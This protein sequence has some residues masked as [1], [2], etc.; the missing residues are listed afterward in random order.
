MTVDLG[1]QGDEG[2]SSSTDTSAGPR[3]DRET[4]WKP[5]WVIGSITLLALALRLFN[6]GE[7][8]LWL[9]EAICYWA[10]QGDFAE[11]IHKTVWYARPL[12]Y[13]HSWP[14]S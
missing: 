11:V 14:T 7:K 13:S 5:V 4:K 10:S 8:S 6:L 3:S 1:N 12:P 9:D 2:A